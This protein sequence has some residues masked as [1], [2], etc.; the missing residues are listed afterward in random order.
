M[1]S[2]L[3]PPATFLMIIY[4][5]KEEMTQIGNPQ[6]LIHLK[7]LSMARRAII[8]AALVCSGGGHLEVPYPIQ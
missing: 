5:D 1:A 4:L 8:E 2:N 6:R 3:R 7:T